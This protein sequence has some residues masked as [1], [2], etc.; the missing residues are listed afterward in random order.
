M[1]AGIEN[2]IP[3]EEIWTAESG[4]F[5]TPCE[6]TQAAKATSFCCAEVLAGASVVFVLELVL[7]IVLGEPQAASTK[8]STHSV[9][10]R[11]IGRPIGPRS[12]C[13][14]LLAL[15]DVRL[16]A[17]PPPPLWRP[18]SDMHRISLMDWFIKIALIR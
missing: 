8:T 7:P 18:M 2:S 15:L 9:A 16:T 17:F 14:A 1:P 10:A 4:K 13:S 11:V 6:R 5:G 12:F 3:L